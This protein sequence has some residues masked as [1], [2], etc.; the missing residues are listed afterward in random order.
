MQLSSAVRS[1]FDF[2]EK[3]L[4]DSGDIER[5]DLDDEDSEDS[6]DRECADSVDVRDF[7]LNIVVVDR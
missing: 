5:D 7:G 2:A 3:L 6:E 4:L 1:C